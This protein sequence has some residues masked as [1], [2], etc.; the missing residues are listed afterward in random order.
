M[1]FSAIKVSD[2]VQEDCMGGREPNWMLGKTVTLRVG[3]E[4]VPR[5]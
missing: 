3:K 1:I 4:R 5:G 2:L